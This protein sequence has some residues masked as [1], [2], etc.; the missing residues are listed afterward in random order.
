[1]CQQG[2]Q[3]LAM[4]L[5]QLIP[6]GQGGDFLRRVE[7]RGGKPPGTDGPSSVSFHWRSGVSADLLVNYLPQMQQGLYRQY[8]QR[9]RL[10]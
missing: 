8:R 7:N 4:G 3:A 6:K 9:R 5:G 1:M 10:A 2:N